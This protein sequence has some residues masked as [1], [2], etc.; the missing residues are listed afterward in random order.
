MKKRWRLLIRAASALGILAAVIALAASGVHASSV[1][2]RIEVLETELARLKK[3]Q[4]ETKEKAVAA[5]KQM[6]L[7]L[8]RPG[9]GLTIAAADDAWELQFGNRLQVLWTLCARRRLHVGSD[10]HAC[11][12][13]AEQRYPVGLRWLLV[14]ARRGY[15]YRAL[16][17]PVRPIHERGCDLGSLGMQ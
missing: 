12:R 17:L 3:E 14:G 4:A 10:V 2:Q 9:N 7:F 11:R 8:Y 1:D 16:V 13:E 15:R 5:E 6:P